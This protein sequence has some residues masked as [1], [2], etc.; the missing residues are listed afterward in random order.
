MQEA[1]DKNQE[2]FVR[3]RKATDPKRLRIREGVCLRQKL[4]ILNINKYNNK[5]YKNK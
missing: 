2:V 5:K 4:Y 3:S 1:N